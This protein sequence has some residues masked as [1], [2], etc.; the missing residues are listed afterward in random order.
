MSRETA[1]RARAAREKLRNVAR[2]R[3]L[4]AAELRAARREWRAR[5]RAGIAA[6]RANLAKLR[7]ALRTASK[8]TSEIARYVSPGARFVLGEAERAALAE[9]QKRSDAE[10]RA[11]KRQAKGADQAIAEHREATAEGREKARRARERA[12]ELR[13]EADDEVRNNLADDDERLLWELVRCHIRG[14]DRMSRTE[15]FY[16]FM[17]DNSHAIPELVWGYRADQ[18]RRLDQA[19]AKARDDDDAE[20]IMREIRAERPRC[21]RD[22]GRDVKR[23]APAPAPVQPVI[24]VTDDV[25]F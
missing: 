14:T 22:L 10:M 8:A 24:V 6:A 1:A 18:D 11:A 19:L 23:K 21:L 12:A 7:A 2:V 25:P 15:A 17:H 16:Q 13:D 3:K 9:V 20:R 4:S 5:G